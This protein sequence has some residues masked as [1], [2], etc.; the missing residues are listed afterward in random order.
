MPNL[1]VGAQLAITKQLSL[2]GRFTRHF[3]AGETDNLP[4]FD[5][6]V[7]SAGVTWQW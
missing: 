6:D 3:D 7:I 2:R 4:G 1:R 5:L